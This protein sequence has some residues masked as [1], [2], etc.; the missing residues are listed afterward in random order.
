MFTITILPSGYRKRKH[1]DSG[2]VGNQSP[3]I[4]SDLPGRV[5]EVNSE[6]LNGVTEMDGNTKSMKKKRKKDKIHER[7]SRKEKQK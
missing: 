3:N 2:Q 7:T 6:R 5:N 4:Q 1:K